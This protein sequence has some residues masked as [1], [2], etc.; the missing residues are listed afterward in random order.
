MKVSFAVRE[1]A[2]IL[3]LFKDSNMPSVPTPGDSISMGG[4]AFQVM[5]IVHV[6]EPT[7]WKV[8]IEVGIPGGCVCGK[9]GDDAP[10]LGTD[11]N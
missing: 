7:G 2:G 6:E 9:C 5:D 10:E 11:W 8:I 3:R 4:D 1:S